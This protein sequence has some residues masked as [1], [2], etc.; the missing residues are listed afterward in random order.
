MAGGR[1]TS[2]KPEYNEMLIEHMSA[3]YSYQTFAAKIKVNL[4]T[5]YNWEKLFPEFSET[6]KEAFEQCRLFWEKQGIDGVWDI[7]EFDEKGKPIKTKR[8]NSAVWIFNMKNRFHW[9]DRVEHSG[10]QQKPILLQYNKEEYEQL[11][12]GIKKED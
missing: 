2:Y 6:K 12:N 1:P 8:L 5:L 11:K 4:D 10:D 7:T 9:T 3:G